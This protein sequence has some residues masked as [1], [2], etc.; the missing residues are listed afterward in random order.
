MTSPHSPIPPAPVPANTPTAAPSP[1]PRRIDWAGLIWLY[2][3]FWYFSGVVQTLLI[4]TAGMTGFRNVLFLSLVWLAPVLLFPHRT[5]QISTVIGILLWAASLV[6]LGYWAIYGQEFSRGVIFTIFETNTEEA[7]EYFSQYV[8]LYLMAG[9]LVYT[10]IAA[11]LWRRLRPVHLPR[12]WAALTVALLVLVNFAYPYVRYFDVGPDLS[13]ATKKLQLRLEPAAPWQLLLGFI[14]YRQQLDNL[15]HLLAGNAAL[16]PL[17]KLTD[18]NGNAP[19]TLVLVI[20]ESTTSQRMSL[21]GYPRPTTPRL[22]ALKTAGQLDVFNDVITSRPYTIE[23][24]QQALTFA[25]QQEPE[26]AFS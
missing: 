23:I 7:G 6:S 24:L 17:E 25:N 21:Y 8:N 16:P 2:L 3:F 12:P 22:D 18:A 26:R 20:G 1:A 13:F 14:Q 10:R 15:E 19:R 9:I 5:R 4:P 11:L